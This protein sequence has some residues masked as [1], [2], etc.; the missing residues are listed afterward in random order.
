MWRKASLPVVAS[1]LV[2]GIGIGIERAVAVE[3]HAASIAPALS[4]LA[5]AAMLSAQPS[6]A[7]RLAV[8]AAAGSLPST[9][10]WSG[11][12]APRARHCC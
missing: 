6:L 10:W 9:W 3:R 11:A 7:A 4:A 8:A 12:S 2:T 5:G 1:V